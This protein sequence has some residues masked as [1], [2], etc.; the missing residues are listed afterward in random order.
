MANSS[1]DTALQHLREQVSGNDQT[2]LEALN[3]RIQLVED[4]KAYK[5]A[6]KLDFF[7]AAQEDRVLADLC[8]ANRGPMT[9]EGL[10]EIFE[11]LLKWT[12]QEIEKFHP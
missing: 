5:K 1:A 4:I 7:D 8:Q 11:Y 9:D 12:K 10:R 2:I 6:Q 3:R